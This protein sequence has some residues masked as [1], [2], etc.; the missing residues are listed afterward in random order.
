[1]LSGSAVNSTYIVLV[2][3]EIDLENNKNSDILL[4][5]ALE[6]GKEV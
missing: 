4:L 3:V 2:I 1:M 5:R 6:A